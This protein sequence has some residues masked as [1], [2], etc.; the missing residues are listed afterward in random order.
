THYGPSPGLPALREAIAEHVARTR[1]IPCSPANVVVTP[2]GKPIMFYVMLALV[3]DGDEVIY[4][5]PGFP[6][7]E[8]MIRFCGGKAVAG[9]LREKREFS[10]DVEEI[11]SLL[12]PRTKLVILNSPQNPT[13][14]V[15]PQADVAALVEVLR[16][17]PDVLVL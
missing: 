1:G 15:M 7:Y 3:D 8:S 17:R 16:K 12:T 2:G 11:A 9:P 14:G 6:I 10:V 5:N 4:P 13:G